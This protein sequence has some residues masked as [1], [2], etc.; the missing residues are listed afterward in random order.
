MVP[1]GTKQGSSGTKVKLS[2]F[3]LKRTAV[4]ER[5]IQTLEDMLRAYVLESERRVGHR[6]GGLKLRGGLVGSRILVMD[7]LEKKSL[8]ILDRQ[9]KQVRN[10]VASAKCAWRNQRKWRVLLGG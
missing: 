8:K 7:A 5:T 6:L 10:E 3:H 4:A 9:V 1:L 2:T